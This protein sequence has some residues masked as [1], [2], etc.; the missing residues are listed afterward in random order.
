MKLFANIK[1]FIYYCRVKII[2]PNIHM[3]PNSLSRLIIVLTIIK[4][5]ALFTASAQTIGNEKEKVPVNFGKISTDDLKRS[6]YA[7]DSTATAIIIADVG[8][9]RIEGNRRGWFS[10]IHT[11]YRRA[12]ILNKSAYD[13][14]NVA[15][16]LYV[17][18]G[19]QEKLVKVKARTYNLEGDKIITTEFNSK[20]IFIDKG[21]KNHI[22]R[23]FTLPNVKEGAIIEYEYIV[24]SDFLFNFQPWSFQGRTPRLWSEYTVE[25]PQFL[26][27]V[28]LSYGYN[29]FYIRAENSLE[30]TF[31]VMD[32]NSSTGNAERFQFNSNVRTTRLVMKDI[33]ALKEEP[34]TSSLAN[35]MSRMEFQ[36][37]GYRE[38]LQIKRIMGNW[39]TSCEKLL[40]YDDF[41]AD[42]A[43]D[44]SW[45]AS[46]I[47]QANAHDTSALANVKALYYYVRN[48]YK[49]T[50]GMGIYLSKPGL[51]NV[52][53]AK[54]GKIAEINLLLTAMLRHA[55]VE[56][57]PVILSTT[58]NGFAEP[59]YPLISQYNYVVVKAIV[60]GN[61]YLLDASS[62]SLPFGKLMPYCYN[63]V[64]RVVHGQGDPILLSA[65][66]LKE[67]SQIY[68]NLIADEGGNIKGNLI[69]RLGDYESIRLKSTLDADGIEG[70]K[71]ELE[72]KMGTEMSLDS[73][74]LV[75][76]DEI[77]TNPTLTYQYSLNN[78]EEDL[79][80]INPMQMEITKQNPFTSMTRN[81]P[82]EMPYGFDEMLQF[83]LLIP[84][85]YT[86]D[87]LP[88]S[89]I[90]TLDEERSCSYEYRVVQ[91]ADQVNIRSRF[92]FGRANFDAEE[93]ETLR[94]FFD[95]V[96]KKQEESIVLKK[97]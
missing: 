21:D 12:H 63:G 66:S 24:S 70:L 50:G 79:L 76:N 64:A 90:I 57:Y 78:N 91:Q 31:N 34:Y 9:S 56:A 1:Y 73:V 51:R 35:H 10:V 27:Y 69:K 89:M 92:K 60:N 20:D 23:K 18:N 15:I 86:V 58:S 75:Y 42:L 33:K 67:A 52:V 82:I 95:L 30:K 97:I 74:R 94:A 29:P 49:C 7:I 85:G 6:I 61:T 40:S 43:K 46:E 62:A 93:Y 44:N 17:D 65:D 53:K 32:N 8:S 39:A 71:K 16:N 5:H 77:D 84:N 25:I 2:R 68:I 80:F 36:L 83:T 11:H 37:S 26:D 87:E 54:G 48:Q 41:G 14:A 45:L 38:P 47:K 4:I 22:T 19:N 13:L 59:F 28:S 88:K 81:Y 3:S 72:K 96:V 55:K